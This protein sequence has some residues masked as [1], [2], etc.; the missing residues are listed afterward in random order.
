VS[1]TV[2]VDHIVVGAGSAGCA[3]AARLA[4]DGR[5]SVL[6]LEAG[7]DDRWIWLRIPAGVA[8]I[9]RGDRSVWRFHTEPEPQMKGRRIFWPRGRVLG[10]SST[11][12][13]MIWAHGDPQEYALWRDELGLDDW[14]PQ[15]M[16]A[17]LRRVER[18]GGGDTAVRGRRGP[19]SITEYGPKQP[20]MRDFL[21][22]CASA[23]IPA[24]PDYN[25]AAYEGAGFLQFNTRRGWRMGAR[26]AYLQPARR[27][28]SLQVAEDAVVQRVLFEGRRAVGVVWRRDGVEHTTR[29]TGDVVLCA[30]ALQSP[31]LLELS[32]IGQAHRLQALGVPVVHDLPAVGENL[33]DHLHTRVNFEVR[34]VRTLNGIM[35]SPWHKALMGLRWLLAGNGLMSVSAQI[36]HALARTTPDAPRVEVKLQLHWLSS[37]DARDPRRLL[38]DPFPG[39]SVGTFPLRPRSRGHVHANSREAAQAPTIV[40][41]YLDHEDDR[42]HTV[43]ALRL[44]RHVMAQPPMQRWVVREDR[45][46]HQAQSDDELIDYVR[47]IGQTSYHPVGSCRMGSDPGSVVDAQL[48]V[49]GVSGL[50]V[51]DASIFPTMP[52]CN[53]N[54]PSMAVGERAADLLLGRSAP[55]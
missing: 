48:R 53:T 2:T 25:S 35:P 26:E 39:L 27:S 3:L 9:V 8:H 14:G 37:P 29:C 52:S 31:V 24:N 6:L 11:I 28:A 41:N 30:G 46:G 16:K 20:L 1:S 5:R 21:A 45:P 19:V 34:D 51:A 10:G 7:R 50:R 55:A 4:Q 15:A 54:A 32:G 12:N 40:A 33:H 42:H 47:G 17:L 44:A 49:R 18:Y 43:A 13:G 23:G 22:A 38:L 36:A